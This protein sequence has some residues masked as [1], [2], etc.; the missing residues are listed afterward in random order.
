[1]ARNW[2]VWDGCEDLKRIAAEESAGL[3]DW[4]RLMRVLS[5]DAEVAFWNARIEWLQ[6][7]RELLERLDEEGSTRSRIDRPA[8]GGEDRIDTRLRAL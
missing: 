1:M 4:P 3:R 6:N 2:R 5:R 8:P 7:A